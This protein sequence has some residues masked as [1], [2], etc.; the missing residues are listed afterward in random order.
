MLDVGKMVKQNQASK[1]TTKNGTACANL[2]QTLVPH[3]AAPSPHHMFPQLSKIYGETKE[4]NIQNT[5]E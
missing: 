1:K 2:W 4:N 3:Y 5:F